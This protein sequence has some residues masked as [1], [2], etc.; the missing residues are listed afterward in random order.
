MTQLGQYN[1]HEELG[2]GGFATVYRATHTTLGNEIALK[3]LSPA[4][5]GD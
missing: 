2:H 5:A 1:L 3:V 4:L